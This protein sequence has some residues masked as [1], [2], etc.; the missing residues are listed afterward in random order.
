MKKN[1]TDNSSSGNIGKK[2]SKDIWDE[3]EVVEGAEYDDIYEHK[4]T[5]RV[6]IS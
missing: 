4:T 6:R 1:V 2:N 3:E 5:A